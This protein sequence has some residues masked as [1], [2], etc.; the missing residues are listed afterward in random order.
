MQLSGQ[1]HIWKASCL[2][3]FARVGSEQL[4]EVHNLTLSKFAAAVAK[5][6]LVPAR[7]QA[8]MREGYGARE[9]WPDAAATD[10]SRVKTASVGDYQQPLHQRGVLQVKH[11]APGVPPR[12]A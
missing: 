1:Q 5:M 10:P 7:Q 9:A 4:G 2:P 8:N 11:E 12:V 3:K 6:S